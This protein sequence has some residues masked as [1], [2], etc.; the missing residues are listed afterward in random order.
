MV[1]S[2][3]GTSIVLGA[4]LLVQAGTLLIL[5][6]MLGAEDFAIF[7]SISALAVLLGTFSTF[8]THLVLL[9]EMSKDKNTKDTILAY[10]IPTTII[11]GSLLFF[12]YLGLGYWLFHNIFFSII[13]FICIGISELILLPLL[14]LIIV[15]D[16]ALE[17]TVKSQVV[18]LLPLLLR[19]LSALIIIFIE[20]ENKLLIFLF[21]YLFSS[22]LS[23]FIVKFL[24]NSAFQT[25][26]KWILPSSLQ[27]KNSAG[28][29]VLALSAL[30]PNELDK[31]LAVK[32]LPLNIGGAYIAASRIIGAATLPVVALILS[33]F[34]KLFRMKEHELKKKNLNYL[35]LK[36]VLV[37]GLLLS[38]ILWFGAPFFEIIFGEKYLGIGEMLQWFCFVIPALT[39]RIA[40]GSLLVTMGRPW[41][42]A[43]FEIFGMV[44]LFFSILI[45]YPYFDGKGIIIALTVAEFFMLIIGVIILNKINT[46][47]SKS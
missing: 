23:L 22:F 31:I 46:I 33:V 2:T 11:I 25:T 24:N 32:L 34:P 3:L 28:Y 45:L 27:L 37:Y 7:A 15:Q 12:I 40:I 14:S 9:G 42:R 38:L 20:M 43:G 26:E 6:R 36:M 41:L 35:I 1:R 8:G 29:A 13:I 17:K 18:A 19:F 21:F 16:I 39:L 44:F 47:H 30:G 5:A 4:R 10:A